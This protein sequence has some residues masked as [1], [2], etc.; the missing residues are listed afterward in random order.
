MLSLFNSVVFGENIELNMKCISSF[1][2]NNLKSRFVGARGRLTA[3]LS[4][5]EQWYIQRKIMCMVRHE[6]QNNKNRDNGCYYDLRH[7]TY[8]KLINLLHIQVIRS[9]LSTVF[10]IVLSVKLL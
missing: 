8:P 2:D 3:Q 5:A 9:T 7:V 4:S 10:I 1:G 6:Y